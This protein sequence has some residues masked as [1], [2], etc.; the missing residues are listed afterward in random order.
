MAADDR[1]P[2][3]RDGAPADGEVSTVPPPAIAPD[4][5]AGSRSDPSRVAASVQGASLARAQATLVLLLA[6]GALLGAAASYASGGLGWAMAALAFVPVLHATLMAVEF[7]WARRSNERDPAGAPAPGRTIV[8]WW[9]ELVH[10]VR[11][12]GLWQ[13]FLSRAPADHLPPDAW[14]RSGVL[15]I[16]GFVCNRG[17]WRRWLHRLTR[18]GTPFVAVDLEPVFGRIEDYDT[19]IEAGV[20]LLEAAT[21]VPPI[22]VAHSMGGLATRH[23]W[24]SQPTTRI[25]HLITI[26]SPHRGTRLARLARAPNARQMREGAAWSAALLAR[27][28]RAQHL[29]TTCFYAHADNI[30]FPASSATLPGADNRHLGAVGHIGMVERPEPFDALLRLLEQ[31]AT[32]T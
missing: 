19:R 1:D 28:P 10:A 29:R 26:G 32:L 9:H 7:F 22:I 8:A 21:G 24:A 11:V 13:P 25:R 4:D 18:R 2:A 30:V 31:D 6:A 5:R 27:Q 14:G 15:L 3:R 17:L 20:R 12:F 23:W 16:H